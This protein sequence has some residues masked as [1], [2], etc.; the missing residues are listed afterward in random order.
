[1]PATHPQHFPDSLGIAP[2]ELMGIEFQGQE[3]RKV[4]FPAAGAEGLQEPGSE[5][6]AGGVCGQASR[7][8]TPFGALQER[9]ANAGMNLLETLQPSQYFSER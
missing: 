1:M 9:A 5:V 6:K 3:M 4:D 8:H 7:G 2:E